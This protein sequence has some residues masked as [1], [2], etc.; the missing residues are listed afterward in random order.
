MAAIGQTRPAAT[1]GI[2]TPLF[3]LGVALALLAF[4]IMF[5]FGAVYVG[6]T[7]AGGQVRVLVAAR[8]IQPREPMSPT[9]DMV[10]VATLPA[11]AVPPR[12]FQNVADVT[13]LSAIVA[14]YKGQPITAN[15]VGNSDQIIGTAQSSYLPIPQGFVAMT[16]PTGEQQG[17]A[18]YI[19]QGD[20][21]N[22][23][24]TVNSGQFSP[25][26][27]RPVAKTV[28]TNL[29]VIRVGPQSVVRGQGQPQ[30]LTSSLTVVMSLCDAQYM[31]WLLQNATLRYVLLSYHDYATVAPS[32]D[33]GCPSVTAPGLIGPAQVDQR[34]SFSK[35]A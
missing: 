16:L 18:G 2:R 15:L 21:I 33:P 26:N 34:W 4:L 28:F 22:V 12:A 5:A 10:T 3:I 1:G 8:D 14:I 9:S 24:A 35:A 27:P 30:G 23:I 31:D 25:V 6:R 13:G 32:P 29:H 17:V 7:Q 19:A 11:S 20:Y